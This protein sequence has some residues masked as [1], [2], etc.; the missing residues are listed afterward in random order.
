MAVIF[1]ILGFIGFFTALIYDLIPGV[2]LYQL[3]SGVLINERLSIIGIFSLYINAFIYLILSFTK[4]HEK[5]EVDVNDF[6]NLLGLYLGLVYIILYYKHFYY[7]ENKKKFYIIISLLIILSILIGIAEFY[8]AKNNTINKIFEWFGVLFNICEYLPLGFNY[9]F[10]IK[11]KI[12]EKY[13]LFGGFFGFINSTFWLIWAIITSNRAKEGEGNKY[14]SIVANIFGILLCLSQFFVFFIFKK[15]EPNEPN[16]YKT[17]DD[18]NNEINQKQE[19]NLEINKIKN[20]DNSNK[21]EQ[22]KDLEDFM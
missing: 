8:I 18:D 15:D 1:S 20:E 16:E 13:T 7:I 9:L 22:D 14:H 12:S 10:L 17:I 3:K 19:I 4:F 2:F 5:E 21:S 6:C 11:N